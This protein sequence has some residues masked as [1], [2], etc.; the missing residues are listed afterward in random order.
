MNFNVNEKNHNLN[1]VIKV[2]NPLVFKILYEEQNEYVNR[3]FSSIEKMY[4]QNLIAKKVEEKISI[5]TKPVECVSNLILSDFKGRI[6]ST[7][8]FLTLHQFLYTQ[9]SEVLQLILLYLPEE[10]LKVTATH[11]VFEILSILRNIADIKQA[12]DQFLEHIVNVFHLHQNTLASLGEL[13]QK[14]IVYNEN[15][16]KLFKINLENSDL[17]DMPIAVLL[18]KNIPDLKRNYFSFSTSVILIKNHLHDSL[19]MLKMHFITVADIIEN[20]LKKYTDLKDHEYLNPSKKLLGKISKFRKKTLPLLNRLNNDGIHILIKNEQ[21]LKDVLS[22]FT[23]LFKACDDPKDIR[24]FGDEELNVCLAVIDF[25]EKSRSNFSEINLDEYNNKKIDKV[26]LDFRPKIKKGIWS[27]A[28]FQRVR[29]LNLEMQGW[30]K[31]VEFFICPIVDNIS[32]FVIPTLSQWY[33]TQSKNKGFQQLINIISP[34]KEIRIENLDWLKETKKTKGNPSKSLKKIDKVV[35]SFQ[36]IS[37]QSLE[38]KNELKPVLS[39]LGQS[40]RKILNSQ[41]ISE[42]LQLIDSFIESDQKILQLLIDE[43]N[44]IDV[45]K[46]PE[47]F[48]ALRESLMYC[49]DIMVRNSWLEKHRSI[50]R[51]QFCL[52]AIEQIGAIYHLLEQILR[53]KNLLAQNSIQQDAVFNSHNLKKLYKQWSSKENVK[54]PDVVDDFYLANY[55]VNYSLEQERLWAS[56]INKTTPS[57]LK[58]IRQLSE[59][60]A[61]LDTSFIRCNLQKYFIEAISFVKELF[62]VKFEK[63]ERKRAF[64]WKTIELTPT[65]SID[66]SRFLIIDQEIEKLQKTLNWPVTS[67]IFDKFRQVSIDTNFLIEGINFLNQ[68][69]GSHEL[70]PAVR[71]VF[72]KLGRV[73]EQLLQIVAELKA[74]EEVYDHEIG[75]I[76][77]KIETCKKISKESKLFLIEE[78][79]KSNKTYRYPFQEHKIVNVFHEIIAESELIRECPEMMMDFECRSGSVK[80]DLNFFE[81]NSKDKALSYETIFNKISQLISKTGI[82]LCK[83]VIEELK[84]ELNS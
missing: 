50:D 14:E 2:E 18:E 31:C 23:K 9:I 60:Q 57:L 8:Y 36:S 79:K 19:R 41:A 37:L 3:K 82:I 22:D 53:Y 21:A 74:G 17:L 56:V 27:F 84:K 51:R 49:M 26:S 12:T 71:T 15:L 61:F 6:K 77:E 32:R 1:I 66:T 42:D 47:A 65:Q 68:S 38:L 40:E 39:G 67:P 29:S 28:E 30:H 58:N 70:S 64:Q 81:L 75:E 16:I 62:P 73:V 44:T 35:K 4:Y 45:G 13:D 48:S 20:G 55:W 25:Y 24:S 33:T 7:H 76:F 72:S 54:I 78:F 83:E 46:F 11:R 52:R 63:I 34:P 10:G 69:I 43:L 5:I 80:T 59:K